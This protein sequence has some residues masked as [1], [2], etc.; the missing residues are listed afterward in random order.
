MERANGP[1]EATRE[2][3]SEDLGEESLFAEPWAADFNHLVW[4]TPPSGMYDAPPFGAK[5]GGALKQGQ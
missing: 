5:T 3:L 4:M 2:T 1:S